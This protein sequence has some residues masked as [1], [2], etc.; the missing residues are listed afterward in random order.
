M[1]VR[2]SF[3]FPA[4]ALPPRLPIT[5][6]W[7]V[8]TSW[9]QSVGEGVLSLVLSVKACFPLR[10]IWAELFLLLTTSAIPGP[11]N[12][13]GTGPVGVFPHPSTSQPSPALLPFLL[14]C[15]F[16]LF[17]SRGQGL[18]RCLPAGV[19]LDATPFVLAKKTSAPLPA[20]RN[21]KLTC[22]NVADDSG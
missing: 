11:N 21:I 5:G 9:T 18:T 1:S 4:P 14:S 3:P 12:T 2:R 20:M 15:Y 8:L 17:W 13:T 10:Q 16:E 7:R 22:A 19:A 6:L